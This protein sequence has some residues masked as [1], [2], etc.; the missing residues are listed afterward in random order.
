MINKSFLRRLFLK[1]IIVNFFFFNSTKY[2]Y[3]IKLF[4]NVR[5]IFF[6]PIT[7][8]PHVGTTFFLRFM[9][10]WLKIMILAF[11]LA[12]NSSTDQMI[13]T[14]PNRIT[15]PST[16]RNREITI[17]STTRNRDAIPSMY[18]VQEGF[19]LYNILKLWRREANLAAHVF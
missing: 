19:T 13:C 16:T 18:S 7:P 15:I 6:F 14:N 10:K 3:V 4:R 9:V 12:L 2:A 5:V 17:P 1:T 8:C 11:T